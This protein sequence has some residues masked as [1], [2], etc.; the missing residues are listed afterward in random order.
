M[1]YVKIILHCVWST[2]DRHPTLAEKSRREELFAHI[3][4]NV[5]EKGLFVLQVGGHIEHIHLLLLLGKEQN[6]SKVIQLIKGEYAHW[7]NKQHID[8]YLKWQDDYFAVSVSESHISRVSDYILRQEEHHKKKTF[9]E[10]YCDFIKV[11]GF[12][13]VG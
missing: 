3:C 2:K 13:K 9:Q 5:K 12:N 11:Y 10:E 4:A 6:I 1:S 7:Y 8:Q